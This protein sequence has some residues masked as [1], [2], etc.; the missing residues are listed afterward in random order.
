[1][2][3]KDRYLFL[4]LS[5]TFFLL[6]LVI[7]LFG[8]ILSAYRSYLIS[9]L[10]LG[11]CFSW[12]IRNK[13]NQVIRFSINLG[14]VGVLAWI[15]YSV[16]NSSLLYKDV[17][18]ICIKGVI[19]LEVIFSFNACV[20]PFLAYI[21]A[22]TIPLF[23]S[24]YI[25]IKDSYNEISIILTLAYFITW[26]AIFRAKFYEFFN[27]LSEKKVKRYYSISLSVIFLLIILISS[28][29]FFSKFPLRQF[30]KGGF[31]PEEG[32]G[33][34]TEI[35]KEYYDLQDNAQE[36][37]IR[38]IPEF[39]ST[40]ERNGIL[41]LLS[42][43]I[44][45]SPYVLEVEKA[46]SGLI[47]YLDKPGPGLEG[48][49]DKEGLTIL[50]RDYMDKKIALNLKRTKDNII[51]VL[52]RYPFDIRTRIHIL[53]RV[54]KMQYGSSYQKISQYE[55]E[56]KKIINNSSLGTNVKTEIKELTRKLKEWKTYEIYRKKLDSLSKSIDSLEEEAKKKFADLP[57]KINQLE[58]P[59]DYKEI[60]KKL[61]NLKETTPSQF[62]DLIK[63]IQEVSDLKL[64]MSLAK[65]NINL[66]EKLENSHLSQDKI[67]E[68]KE[69][70]NSITDAKDYQ[71]LF[72]DS[73]EFKKRTEEEN[74]DTFREL[75]QLLETKTYLFTK[76]GKEKIEDM[77]KESALSDAQRKD[78]LKDIEKLES[79]KDLEKLFSD[80]KKLEAKIDKFLNQGFILK[81]TK[82]NL[83]KEIDRF[84]GLLAS[85]LEA[86]EKGLAKETSPADPL[87][88]WEELIEKSSLKEET[89][90]TLK[91]LTEEL[92]RADTTL[93]VE[94][95]NQAIEKE[96]ASLSKERVN[97]NEAERFKEAFN[98]LIKIKRMFIIEK[99]FSTLREKIEDLKKL[100]PQEAEKLEEYLKKISHTSSNEDL[101]KKIDSLREYSSSLTQQQEKVSEEAQGEGSLQIYIL[102]SRLI[103]PIGSSVPLKTIAVYNKEFIK[104]VHSELE[105]FSSQPL[106][107]SVDERGIVHS[108]SK[109]KTRINANYRGRYS[110]KAEVIVV[111]KISEQIGK[112]V[113]KELVR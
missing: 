89:K 4:E 32:S 5:L 57:L 30:R 80:T 18:L 52:K 97:K 33:E 46:E 49:K 19:I 22:L 81:E 73:A 27:P 35:E 39:D 67:T 20:S 53:S 9:G 41:Y 93:N 50:M 94:N 102:P 11:F 99:K 74:I 88:K 48:K 111:D 12:F 14:A 29:I 62:K 61:R 95:I 31:F 42:L 77:L 37:I 71:A 45:D 76:E 104:E 44:K 113:K 59:S 24:Y 38:L 109:G 6:F 101:E 1:M 107:V 54:N 64:E 108:L 66:K 92:S 75:K 87:R 83:V 65:K 34:E 7:S 55:N 60:N 70:A 68:L 103:I 86:R 15:I 78:F 56:L 100:N 13:H 79:V 51:D 47:S 16:L 84:K 43:L 28:W 23:M 2:E 36:E 3:K 85:Q 91:K 82:D 25:F 72:K 21:Q 96:L 58:D 63:E 90:E 106:V 40:E 110:G 8:E 112:A 10:L 26:L 98:E 69:G 17:I 105:W